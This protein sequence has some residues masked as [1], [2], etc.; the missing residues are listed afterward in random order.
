[1]SGTADID[2]IGIRNSNV[3]PYDGTLREIQIYSSTS[4]KLI[5][6]VISH[7]GNLL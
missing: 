3:N 2:A 5:S 1:M 7:L 6:N 4:A